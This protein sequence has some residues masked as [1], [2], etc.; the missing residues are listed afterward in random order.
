MGNGAEEV[1]PRQ[2][3]GRDAGRDITK[4]TTDV[5]GKVITPDLEKKAE[6][7]RLILGLGDGFHTTTC[8][9]G[10]SL[11]VREKSIGETWVSSTE[12]DERG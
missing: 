6:K 8:E 4:Q 7:S 12:P 9:T 10:R 3:V 11:V 1:G 5:H 2:G